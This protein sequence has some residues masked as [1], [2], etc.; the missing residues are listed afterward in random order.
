[1][2]SGVCVQHG[3]EI[4][5]E[6]ATRGEPMQIMWL[7][8]ENGSPGDH[9]MGPAVHQV[10][11]RARVVREFPIHL[12]GLQRWRFMVSPA[13]RC[14]ASGLVSHFPSYLCKTAWSRRAKTSNAV[15]IFGRISLAR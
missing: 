2:G 11:V 13:P 5:L 9:K 10:A 1:M 12:G 7:R 3:V 8:D 14:S 6:P 15:E 4:Q